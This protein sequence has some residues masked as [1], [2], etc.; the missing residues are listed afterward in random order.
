M[1]TRK[2]E[3]VKEG[4]GRRPVLSTTG[5]KN[6]G[7]TWKVGS[8]AE[9]VDG[10]RTKEPQRKN[11]WDARSRG[12]EGAMSKKNGRTKHNAIRRYANRKERQG[13]EKQQKDILLR[14]L[15]LHKW[16]GGKKR[17]KREFA[18]G[19]IGL[20][21]FA[22]WARVRQQAR[23]FTCKMCDCTERKKTLGSS[24]RTGPKTESSPSLAKG[25]RAEQKSNKK[26]P[27]T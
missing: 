14:N 9:V 2:K 10:W 25:R 12:G 6:G 13:Y 26:S 7:T 4:E 17:V 16:K 8:G 23:G 15:I 21:F 24:G 19:V 1:P 5:R 22:G 3:G 11:P 27:S 20:R 18:R